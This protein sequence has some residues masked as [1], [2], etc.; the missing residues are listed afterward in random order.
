MHIKFLSIVLAAT[1]LC[2]PAQA[3]K[4]YRCGST[5]QDRAC[6]ANLDNNVVGNTR[7][8]QQAPKLVEDAQCSSRGLEAQKI[9]WAREAGQTADVQLSKAGTSHFSP[10][11]ISAVYRKRGTALEVRA[12]IETDCMTEKERS[13]QAAALRQAAD[14]LSPQNQTPAAQVPRPSSM[15]AELKAADARRQEQE[16]IRRKTTCEGIVVAQNNVRDRQ[17][18]GGSANQMEA[19]NKE[20][21][22]VEKKRAESKC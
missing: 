10:E 8:S 15:E 1:A 20:L 21:R 14:N 2:A 4:M 13:L 12:A 19:L 16:A 17:R 18:A 11:L 7:S 5:F 22:E 6:D 3:Q 9:M